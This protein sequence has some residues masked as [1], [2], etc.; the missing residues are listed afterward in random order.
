MIE[1]LRKQ[2][3]EAPEQREESDKGRNRSSGS[4]FLG[5]TPFQ[6]FVIAVMLLITTSL[7]GVF[8]LMVMGKI[9]F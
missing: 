9:V 3:N 1:D 7:I 2:A 6:R 4:H 5:M 8:V